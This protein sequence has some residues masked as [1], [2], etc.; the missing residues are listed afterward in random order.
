[1]E[2]RSDSCEPKDDVAQH[3]I[4]V[5]FDKSRAGNH[6]PVSCVARY[7]VTIGL[8]GIVALFVGVFEDGMAAAEEEDF[9]TGGRAVCAGTFAVAARCRVCGWG[10]SAGDRRD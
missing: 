10:R 5:R 7:K 4:G 9:T 8:R 2:R 6:W 3:R 1:M